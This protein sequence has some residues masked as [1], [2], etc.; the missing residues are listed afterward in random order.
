MQLNFR[1]LYI[2]F[3]YLRC[4]TK[5]C[6]RKETD[7]L[8]TF[9]INDSINNKNSVFFCWCTFSEIK[10][11]RRNKI[12]ILSKHKGNQM[13]QVQRFRRGSSSRIQ[14]ELLPSL[15]RVQYL[16]E[17]PVITFQLYPQQIQIFA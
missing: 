7:T 8:D 10:Q 5:Q 11:S 2:S 16:I 14:I 6:T 12:D 4:A 15:V 1:H 13:P 17:V 9:S 3:L